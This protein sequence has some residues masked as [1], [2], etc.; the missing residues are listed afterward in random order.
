MI[1]QM[2]KTAKWRNS[3][4]YTLFVETLKGDVIRLQRGWNS[5]NYFGLK[6]KTYK[7]YGKLAIRSNFRFYLLISGKASH[8]RLSSHGEIIIIIMPLILA[9]TVLDGKVNSI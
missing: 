1:G 8:Q 3:E 9:P 2:N 7:K 5:I 4:T 6:L